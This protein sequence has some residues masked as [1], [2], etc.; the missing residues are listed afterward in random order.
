MR[1]AVATRTLVS[2][3]SAGCFGEAAP[4]GRPDVQRLVDY[5]APTIVIGARVN[6][7]AR[8]KYSL[9][10]APYLGYRDSVYV[11]PDG[12]R[13]L[14]L[15]VTEYIDDAN[16]TVSRRAR[17]TDVILEIP[18]TSSLHAVRRRL[19]AS[20]GEPVEQCHLSQSGANGARTLVHTLR[21]ADTG[22][23]T[24]VTYHYAPAPTE[25]LADALTGFTR[26]VLSFAAAPSLSARHDTISC[27]A[28]S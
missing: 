19:T 2:L 27:R 9:H 18:D 22:D 6:N 26:G 8:A 7:A 28:P 15:R 25:S 16:P 3:L 13:N 23:G 14:G 5:Y 11:A 1:H 21:W 17:V 12:A 24:I 20:L 4:A 10:P